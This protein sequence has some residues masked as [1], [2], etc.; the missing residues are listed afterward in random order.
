MQKR[1]VRRPKLECG[2]LAGSVEFT[3]KKQVQ[4]KRRDRLRRRQKEGNGIPLNTNAPT[5]QP[6]SKPQKTSAATDNAG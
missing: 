3:A 2:Y 4:P 1:S 5:A 6:F